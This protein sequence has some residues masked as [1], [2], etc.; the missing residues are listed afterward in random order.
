MGSLGARCVKRELCFTTAGL[1]ARTR[2]SV[3]VDAG[4]V[5]VG[6]ETIIYSTLE[7]FRRFARFAVVSDVSGAQWRGRGGS[8]PYHWG[9]GVP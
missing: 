2:Q 7:G 4:S 1:R 5:L 8:I 6:D 3:R 9:S